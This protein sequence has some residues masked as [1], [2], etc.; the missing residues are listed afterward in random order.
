MA[1]K[2]A[3][4]KPVAKGGKKTKPQYDPDSK[5]SRMM[6]AKTEENLT[7]KT[8]AVADLFVIEYLRDY[9]AKR[10]FIRTKAI[11]DPYQEVD[12]HYAQNAGYQMTRWPYVAAKIQKAIEE[13]EEKN[14]VTRA[15]VLHGLKREALFQGPGASH[16][17]RVGGW[18]K[19][20]QI[21]G[22]DSKQVE[23]GLAMRGGIMI[24]PAVDDPRSWEERAAA[25]QSALKEEVRK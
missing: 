11:T 22:M 17:A 8:K 13:A 9:N 25:A 6:A 18:G 20:A 23:R 16:S 2:K 10:A 12:E 19:L 14:I 7:P 1:A 24:V 3:P 4:P 15:E 21:M 5:S